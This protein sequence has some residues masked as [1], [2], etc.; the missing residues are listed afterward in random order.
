MSFKDWL[1]QRLKEAKEEFQRKEAQAR[2]QREEYERIQAQIKMKELEK[3]KK[4]IGENP[5]N[6]QKMMFQRYQNTFTYLEKNILRSDEQALKAIPVEYDKRKNTEIDGVLVATDQRLIFAYVRGYNQ[7]IEDWDYSK[8][9]G[10][11]LYKDDGFNQV[12]LHLEIGRSKKKFDDIKNNRDLVEFLNIVEKYVN[13]SRSLSK[14]SKSS[15]AN[16]TNKV[17][18]YKLL[19]QIAKLKEQGIL[20]E[21]EFEAEKQKILNS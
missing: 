8:I 19:E 15:P 5:S 12:E 4:W 7:V 13:L 20:T 11:Q 14:G 18:K 6:H 9:K 16:S 2:K 3:Q 10:I 17:D 1:K 21:E